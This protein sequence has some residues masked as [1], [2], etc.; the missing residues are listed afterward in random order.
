[1]TVGSGEMICTAWDSLPLRVLCLETQISAADKCSLRPAAWD[2]QMKPMVMG[3]RL[4]EQEGLWAGLG[5]L[6]RLVNSI[7]YPYSWLVLPSL[8]SARLARAPVVHRGRSRGFSLHCFPF[9]L[10]MQS[11]NFL[12][13]FDVLFNKPVVY[14]VHNF[15]VPELKSSLIGNIQGLGQVAQVHEPSYLRSPGKRI[16]HSKSAWATDWVPGQLGQ[17]G[18]NLSQTFIKCPG[19]AT[20]KLRR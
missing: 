10:D 6:F 9:L 17:L 20:R 11:G 8:P 1:M 14:Q 16:R 12:L 5:I 18:K 19:G 15:L 3:G 4:S 7:V 13:E 2:R